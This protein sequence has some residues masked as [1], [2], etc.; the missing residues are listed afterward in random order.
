MSK[1]WEYNG[2]TI[3]EGMKSRDENF[4]DNYYRYFF[5]VKK[6]GERKFKYCIWADKLTLNANP[7]WLAESQASGHKIP[8]SIYQQA[9]DRVKEKIDGGDYDNRLLEFND[10]V[11]EVALDDLDRKME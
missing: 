6:D 10:E 9:L 3:D 11:N 1:V 8:E 4:K 7:V 5:L 2:F